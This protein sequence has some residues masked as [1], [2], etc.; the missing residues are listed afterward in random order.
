MIAYFNYT[1]GSDT[2]LHAFGISAVG[3]ALG[4]IAVIFILGT[5]LYFAFEKNKKLKSLLG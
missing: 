1:D 5:A 4:E 3:V 2:F